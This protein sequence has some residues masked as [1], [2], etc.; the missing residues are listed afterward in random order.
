M[1]KGIYMSFRFKEFLLGFLAVFFCSLCVMLMDFNKIINTA[2]D[3]ELTEN[4]DSKV[5]I[6]IDAGHGEFDGGTQSAS[7]VLEK[8]VN[9]DISLLLKNKL[10][11][12]DYEVVMI[13]DTD[14]VLSD[15]DA[16]TIREKK[17]SDLHN[18]LKIVNEN[19]DALFIS[20][21]QNYFTQSQYKGTQVFYS[22]NN[23]ESKILA[24]AIQTGVCENLQKDNTRQIK[25]SGSEIFL[26]HKSD[27]V[28][29]MIECGF[30]SN[31]EEAELLSDSNYQKELV[32][33]IS[34]SIDNYIINKG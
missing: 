20:V 22:V 23:P 32:R 29:V 2:S 25:P 8:D 26:L 13:R 28:A 27:N 11:S 15:P 30:L 6:I 17:S 31:I 33:V 14:I 34:E 3:I 1:K 16:D 9:L 7:G 24:Q 10:E 12:M 5:K 4:A 19:P 18:R 21:H